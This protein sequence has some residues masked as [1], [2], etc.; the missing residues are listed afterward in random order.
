[1]T[2]AQTVPRS[3]KRPIRKR[4]AIPCE[5]STAAAASTSL[6]DIPVSYQYSNGGNLPLG[7]DATEAVDEF[8]LSLRQPKIDNSSPHNAPN[9][10]DKVSAMDRVRDALHESLQFPEFHRIVCLLFWTTLINTFRQE[11]VWELPLFRKQ[12]GVTWQRFASFLRARDIA[13]AVLKTMPFLLGQPVFRLICDVF[14]QAYGPMRDAS[15]VVA[16]SISVQC[17]Y[18]LCGFFVQKKTVQVLRR[19]Y[20]IAAVCEHPHANQIMAAQRFDFQLTSP[21]PE[22]T[23]DAEDV[24]VTPRI[25]AF[26]DLQ[27]HALD[28]ASVA[29]VLR[30][31]E[32]GPGNRMQGYLDFIRKGQQVYGTNTRAC[33]DG[34]RDTMCARLQKSRATI[35]HDLSRITDMEM[36]RHE[37]LLAKKIDACHLEKHSEFLTTWMSPSAKQIYGSEGTNRNIPGK[38]AYDCFRIKMVT[39]NLNSKPLRPKTV[40]DSVQRIKSFG[41]LPDVVDAAAGERTLAGAIRPSS[42]SNRQFENFKVALGGASPAPH[43]CDGIPGDDRHGGGASKGV[44]HQHRRRFGRSGSAMPSRGPKKRE[45]LDVALLPAAEVVLEP[46]QRLSR[47]AVAKRVELSARA[48][49]DRSWVEFNKKYDLVTGAKKKSVDRDKLFKDEQAYLN[50]VGRLLSVSIKLICKQDFGG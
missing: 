17:H 34:G 23:S 40:G 13:D 49:K 10:S 16:E 24:T 11:E 6:F 48:V 42:T 25:L 19:R 15:V 29:A 4:A 44:S 32:N 8:S 37:G 43:G 35:H 20:F 41:T 30:G 39:R 22:P 28:E 3:A 2:R 46:P 5:L 31:R 18:E 9:Y 12:L 47:E 50:D 33:S 27:G 38:A 14:P 45:M 1:M 7:A 26:G 21:P 36:K